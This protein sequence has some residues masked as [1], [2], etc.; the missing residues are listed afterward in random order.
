MPW[1]PVVRLSSKFISDSA[2][3]LI[4]TINN[5]TN[6]ST[7]ITSV[8]DYMAVPCGRHLYALH[9]NWRSNDNCLANLKFLWTLR[10]S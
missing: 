9:I 7:S 4:I 3:Q 2:F 1:T 8:P 5:P 6:N 10:E